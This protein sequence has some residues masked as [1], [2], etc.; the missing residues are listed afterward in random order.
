MQVLF[1]GKS[2]LLFT[3]AFFLLPFFTVHRKPFTGC[4]KPICRER[5]CLTR[6]GKYAIKKPFIL[7]KP[8]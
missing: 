7:E 4:N 1:T 5:T 8:G 3:F 6:N 2:D